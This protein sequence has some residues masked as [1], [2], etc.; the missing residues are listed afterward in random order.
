MWLDGIT[1]VL[2]TLVDLNDN[3]SRW[4]QLCARSRRLW[5]ESLPY[6]KQQ[7]NSCLIEALVTTREE[8]VHYTPTQEDEALITLPRHTCVHTVKGSAVKELLRNHVS[9]WVLRSTIGA[10]HKVKT[11]TLPPSRSSGGN[12]VLL[13][14]DGKITHNRG[15]QWNWVC[16]WVKRPRISSRASLRRLQTGALIK[17]AT[18]GMREASLLSGSSSGEPKLYRKQHHHESSLDANQSGHI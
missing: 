10:A 6:Y 13:L 1:T 7:I 15:F 8:E 4:L 2:L 18:C 9:L 17:N 12:L 3:I 14:H 11:N 5:I 16:V